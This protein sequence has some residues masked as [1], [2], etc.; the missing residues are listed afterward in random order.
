[1]GIAGLLG[2]LIMWKMHRDYREWD[3]REGGLCLKNKWSF[4]AG[5]I[6][7]WTVGLGGGL[8]C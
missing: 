6:S 1:M 3:G 8:E 2:E 5:V 4:H 7:R